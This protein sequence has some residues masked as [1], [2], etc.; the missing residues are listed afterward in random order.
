VS[1]RSRFGSEGRALLPTFARE[2][3]IM[4]ASAWNTDSDPAFVVHYWDMGNDANALL[5]AELGLP[6]IPRFNAFNELVTT[7]IK[8]IAVPIAGDQFVPLPS[9]F[10]GERSLSPSDFRYLRVVSEVGNV[11]LPEFAALVEG[12]MMTFT[13]HAEWYLGDTYLNITGLAGTVSQLW[14]IPAQDADKA[15]SRLKDAIWLREQVIQSTPRFQV[16][17]ATPMDPNFHTS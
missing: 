12:S 16:L 3:L 11:Y 13:K 5:E 4:T 7:E 10:E 1:E 14:I 8:S 17:H 9:G 15:A 2:H 6:D